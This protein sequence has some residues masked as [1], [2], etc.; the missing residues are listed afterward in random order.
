VLV[1]ATIIHYDDGV[2]SWIWLHVVK[3]PFNKMVKGVGAKRALD[4][5]AMENSIV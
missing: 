1:D 2:R 3:E 4:N 5:I